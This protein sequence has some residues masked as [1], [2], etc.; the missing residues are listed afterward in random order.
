MKRLLEGLRTT[1][2]LFFLG[3]IIL[4]LVVV[5]TLCCIWLPIAPRKA[6]EEPQATG[7]ECY[8]NW[9]IEW[10]ANKPPPFEYVGPGYHPGPPQPRTYIPAEL[11]GETKERKLQRVVY[12]SAPWLFP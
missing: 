7:L 9:V 2:L 11:P 5:F 3:D 12:D 8:V 10:I 1:L 4:S 6:R